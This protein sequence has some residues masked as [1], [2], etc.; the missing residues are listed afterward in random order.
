[1]SAWQLHYHENAVDDLRR[2]GR[3]EAQG[4]LAAMTERVVRHTSPH[5]TGELLVSEDFGAFWRY[6]LPDCNVLCDIDRGARRVTV[7]HVAA[8]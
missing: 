6:R 1:M 3:R 7:L 2:L 5:E 8:G 4:V